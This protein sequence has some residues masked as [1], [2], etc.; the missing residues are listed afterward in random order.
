M[1]GLVLYVDMI[2]VRNVRNQKVKNNKEGRKRITKASG[3]RW[4]R[5]CE[6][7]NI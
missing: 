2:G 1:G 4:E 6:I 5:V 3:M 7:V